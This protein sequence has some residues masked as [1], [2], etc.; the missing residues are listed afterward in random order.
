MIVIRRLYLYA[1]SFVSLEIVLWGLISLARSAVTIS[2]SGDGR[3]R[4]AEALSFLLVGLPVLALHWVLAQRQ[5]RADPEERFA[6]T[7]A[8]FL[9]A[10]WF[11]TLIP[12]TQNGL[13]IL[14]RLLL[15]AF[16][17]PLRGAVIGADQTW[18]DNLIAIGMNALVAGYVFLVLRS[19]WAAEPRGERYPFL[20]RAYRYAWALYGLGLSILGI[21]EAVEY[22]L[23]SPTAS[24]LR[25]APLANGLAQAIVGLPVGALA[26]WRIQGSLAQPGERRSL[27]RLILLFVLTLLGMA[28]VLIG[29]GRAL[30]FGLTWALGE[31]FS[32][33]EFARRISTPLSFALPLSAVWAGIGRLLAAE[34]Q[35]LPDPQRRAGLRRLFAHIL[36]GFGLAATF[37]GLQVGVALLL[38][39]ALGELGWGTEA[40]ERL[41]AAVA[42]LAVGLPL[43]LQ[44]WRRQSRECAQPGEAGD[45]ARRSVVRKGYL[46]LALFAAVV[47]AMFS[48]GG[49]INLLLRTL[50]GS[51]PEELLLRSLQTLATLILFV[52][53]GFYHWRVL[54][55][56]AA[57]AERSLAEKHA[58]YP[59]LVLDPGDEAFAE[60]LVEA[61]SRQMPGLPVAVRL[62]ADGA[63]GEELSGAQAVILPS[64]LAAN[65]PEAYRLWLDSFKGQRLVVPQPEPGWLWLADTHADA[66]GQ[67]RQA[68]RLLRQ[69]AEGE[70]PGEGL[71][72]S[73]W[74]LVAYIAAGLALFSAVT[75]LIEAILGG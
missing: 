51:P 40:R 9:Y 2:P 67:A 75:W 73:G 70:A 13:A 8:L 62:V 44:A 27:L 28:G 52:L 35:S 25:R 63:P 33:G 46:Y 64:T 5:S 6:G 48:A 50:L 59:V 7:R 45:H 65:P 55:R 14:S 66:E 17:A 16:G 69:L 68:A 29:A 41:S 32:L 37:I 3:V 71:R 57:L 22:L 15:L 24:A 39:L 58:G 23:A 54:R 31:S 43:W 20:R 60:P 53:L 72:L 18:A 49:L 34:V 74:T 47:G 1:I 30:Y 21:Q 36:A 61:L 42:T 56:D 4:L 38:D 19:D 11:A 10:A 12:I 26:Y